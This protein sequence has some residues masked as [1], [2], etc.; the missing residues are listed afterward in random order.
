MEGCLVRIG[1]AEK[2]ILDILNFKR[3][4]HSIDL[5]LEKIREYRNTI[6]FSRL[7]EFSK[8]QSVTVKRVLGFLF[9]KA[10]IDSSYLYNSVKK[11]T[12]NSYMTKDSK[13][14]NAKWRLYYHNHFK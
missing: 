7:N 1:T 4:A 10:D 5:V 12:S 2:A 14:F 3:T 8:K 11:E 6:D 13:L 9:D